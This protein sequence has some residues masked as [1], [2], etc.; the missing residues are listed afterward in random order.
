L[1]IKKSVFDACQAKQIIADYFKKMT[2][3]SLN[4]PKIK[5]RR[6]L[7]TTTDFYF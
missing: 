1:L 7:K 3:L 4:K 2:N 6:F 5:I